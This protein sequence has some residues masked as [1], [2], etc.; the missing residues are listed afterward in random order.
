MNTKFK[1]L[2]FLIIITLLSACNKNEDLKPNTEAERQ[3]AYPD[4]SALTHEKISTGPNY[5]EVFSQN[6]VTTINLTITKVYW[7]SAFVNME[8]LAGYGFGSRAGTTNQPRP[9]G[10][11]LDAIPGDPMYIE[12]DLT[13]KG[14]KWSKVGFRFKGNS[15]L[16]NSW[17]RGINKMPF[18]LQFDEYEDKYP[19]LKDQRFYGFKE[20]S[21][22]PAFGDNSFVREK[23]TSEIFTEAGVPVARNNF[24]KVFID[25]GNGSG[26][27]YY[28]LYTMNEVIDDSAVKSLFKEEKGNVYKPESNFTTFDQTKF[29]KKNNTTEN[30]FSDVRNVITA[31]NSPT[32]LSNPAQWRTELEK[33]FDLE[34]FLQYLAVN[35]TIVNWDCYGVAAHN[36]YIYTPTT[37]SKVTWI[38]WDFS[39]S[40]G[41]SPF[42]NAAAA[43]TLEMKEK[44]PNWPLINFIANDPEL[45]ARYIAKCKAYKSKFSSSAINAKIDAY[46]T[47]INADVQA[48]QANYT[49]LPN[50]AAFPAAI[51][52]LKNHLTAREAALNTFISR[53]P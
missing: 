47:L 5:A 46:A 50:K 1:I 21:M 48:E 17:G 28:G 10:N 41:N 18:K 34:I 2:S 27:Q 52:A 11:N 29:E 6:S 45:Y 39:S 3:S 33:V 31:L 25:N 26:P 19:L 22:A 44:G 14:K 20:F 9:G 37:T 36:Y 13:Y 42:G 32:R 7:D 8:K 43:V 24:C 51:T 40:M 38:P 23:V 4:W 12:A 15:S 16:A 35:N 30:D 53:N 49:F